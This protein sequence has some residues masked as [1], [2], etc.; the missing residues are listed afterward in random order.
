[1]KHSITTRNN[2]LTADEAQHLA[3]F[4]LFSQRN[5]ILRLSPELNQD[6]ISYPQFFLLAYLAEEECLSMSSIARMMGHST[7][8]ATG[9]VD[10]LQELGHLKRFT[11]AAD[12]RK[13]MV[14]IT[15]QGRELIARMRGNIARDLADLM[16]MEDNA[17]QLSRART[18][19]KRHNTT[20]TLN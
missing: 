2:A 19:I 10:K 15:D 1:M 9:M 11:A 6:K 16:A 18:L 14:R 20:S 8:A 7:A 13:I 3:D 17:M 4:V 12:R 5:C